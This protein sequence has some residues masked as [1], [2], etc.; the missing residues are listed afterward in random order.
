MLFVEGR[1]EEIDVLLVHFVFCKL[2]ALAEALEVN[3]FAF[4]EE[5]DDIIYVGVIAEAEDVVIGDAGFLFGGKVFRQITDHI[6][7]D[8]HGCG[9]I[10]PT[11]GSGGV[12]SCRVIHEVGIK[13]CGFDLIFAQ[14][15][16][17]LM[18]NGADH[19][20]VPEFFCTY[21]RV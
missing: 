16:G 7:L 4:P 2:Q 15:A 10:G 14:I 17:Q 19:L 20:Q 9:I 21:K 1:I 6:T 18:D 5:T 12:D 11:G 13:A 8:C 3:D